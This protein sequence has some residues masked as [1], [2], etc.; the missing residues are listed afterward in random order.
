MHNTKPTDLDSPRGRLQQASAKLFQQQGFAKTTVRDI[1]ASVGI[2]SGSIFHHFKNKEQI[3]KTVIIDAILRVLVP[4]RTI[5]S[6]SA[7]IEDRF[8]RLILCELKAIHNEQ[9]DGFR[10]MISEWRS[11]NSDNR[12]EILVLRDEYEKIWL[13][14]LS[15]AYQ[16][17]LV[18][19]ESFYLRSFVRGALIET[20]NWYKPDGNLSLDQLADKL[21]VTFLN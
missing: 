1:A 11:L 5:L 18:S 15:L 13:H 12:N 14:V 16:E 9:L 10:L 8:R 7:N 17:D 20:S 21:C 2:Q 3:L 4:M 19:I 6:S